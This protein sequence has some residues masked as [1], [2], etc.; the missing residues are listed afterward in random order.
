MSTATAPAP[1]AVAPQ[2]A[3][4]PAPLAAVPAAAPAQAAPAPA[5][6]PTIQ[7]VDLSAFGAAPQPGQ[8]AQAAPQPA[9][10]TTAPQAQPTAPPAEE[11]KKGLFDR[12]VGFVKE[13]KTAVGMTV[14]AGVGLAVGNSRAN[15]PQQP[16]GQGFRAPAPQQGPP[17]GGG[18]GPR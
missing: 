8:A 2:P 14:A 17:R 16:Q 7:H 6:Q 12:F 4:A 3:P 15:G 11:E 13:N 18:H 9:P 5:P 10:G 1:A